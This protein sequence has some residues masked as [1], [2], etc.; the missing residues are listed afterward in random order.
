MKE[1]ER[2]RGGG[3]RMGQRV[4]FILQLPSSKNT[5]INIHCMDGNMVK[6]HVFFLPLSLSVTLCTQS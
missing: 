2:E 6:V 1:R 5:I 3:S 4:M